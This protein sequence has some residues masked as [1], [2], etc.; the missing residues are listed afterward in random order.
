MQIHADKN[1]Y[2]SD[3]VLPSMLRSLCVA[4]G[5]E[6]NTEMI[7]DRKASMY[8]LYFVCYGTDSQAIRIFAD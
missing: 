2:F 6:S 5:N 1:P 7:Y 4:N 3:I 8:Y